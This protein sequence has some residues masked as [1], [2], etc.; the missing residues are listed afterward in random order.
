MYL[1]E[2]LSKL[3]LKRLKMD[4]N[5]KKTPELSDWQLFCTFVLNFYLK[6]TDIWRIIK[7]LDNFIPQRT[8]RNFF[9]KKCKIMFWPLSSIVKDVKLGDMAK[10]VD[11]AADVW[12]VMLAVVSV[13]SL[14]KL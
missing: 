11:H 4:K 5:K 10:T 2:L 9:S 7:K 14:Y 12:R 13:V 6:K 1:K 3:L 8:Y